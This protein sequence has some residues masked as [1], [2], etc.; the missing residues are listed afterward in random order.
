[1]NVRSTALAAVFWL[2]LTVPTV[3]FGTEINADNCSVVNQG[4]GNDTHLVCGDVTYVIGLTLEQFEA[5]LKARTAEL[6]DE[7]AFLR[8]TLTA[9]VSG[10]EVDAKTIARQAQDLKLAEEALN[11]AL[12]AQADLK[13]AYDQT[14]IENQ[15]LK[16]ELESFR[17][18]G[19]GIADERFAAAE[20]ALDRGETGAAKAILREIK[21]LASDQAAIERQAKA[22]Y[23]LGKIAENEIDYRAA[24]DHFIRAAQL[25]PEN[26]D[27]LFEAQSLANS[28]GDYGLALR[29]AQDYFILIKQRHSEVSEEFGKAA[30][31]LAVSLYHLGRYDE[32]GPL[33]RSALEV[34]LRVFGEKHS[35]TARSHNNLA[36]NLHRKRQYSEA[37]RHYRRGLEANLHAL[38]NQHKNTAMSYNNVAFILNE[39]GRTREAEDYF[40]RSLSIFLS[41][42]DSETLLISIGYNNLALNLL[43]QDRPEE[44]EPLL[45]RGLEIRTRI[46]GEDHPLTALNYS[47]VSSLRYYQGRIAEAEKYVRKSLIILN[48]TLGSSHPDTKIVAR[49]LQQLLAEKAERK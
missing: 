44:A 26:E 8:K 15:R 41:V 23:E 39:Q 40:R 46:L 42:S 31:A 45:L 18:A 22:S 17:S 2:P 4:D 1:M 3:A 7:V 30:N 24:K 37:E 48:K 21:S 27:Y 9:S 32:A 35:S 25:V 10:G 6:R 36:A 19:L 38:G 33:Y 28:A 29:Y 11:A 47:Y 5:R 20:A 13:T 14:V 49:Q 12:T 16:K 43:D 34:N